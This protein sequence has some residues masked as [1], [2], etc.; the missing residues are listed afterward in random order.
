MAISNGSELGIPFVWPSRSEVSWEEHFVW[1]SRSEVSC[2]EHFVWPSRS[3]VSWEYHFVWA[4][5][6][7]VSWECHVFGPLDRE[8]V[9]SPMFSLNSR[10]VNQKA[11][12]GRWDL[13]QIQTQQLSTLTTTL[14]PSSWL[15]PPTLAF[16]WVVGSLGSFNHYS[17]PCVGNTTASHVLR[18][19][20]GFVAALAVCFGLS[21]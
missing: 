21:G 2:E 14:H 18:V 8:Q 12:A 4:S 7:E 11:V 15:K 19:V 1:A 17:F 3:E 20:F 10:C 9:S 16:G 6:S 13:Q 5:R